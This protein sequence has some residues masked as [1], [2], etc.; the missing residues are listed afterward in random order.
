MAYWSHYLLLLVYPET[1][2]IEDN[3]AA[4]APAKQTRDVT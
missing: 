1:K 4:T 3:K 2:E